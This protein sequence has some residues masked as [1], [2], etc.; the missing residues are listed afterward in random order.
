[1]AA[2]RPDLRRQS[3]RAALQVASL[4]VPDQVLEATPEH[5]PLEIL[6]QQSPVPSGDGSLSQD[7]TAS[8][9]APPRA[10][11]PSAVQPSAVAGV[12]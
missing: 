4:T 3:G 8:G 9:A 2:A 10:V 12:S 7:T 5:A 11:Q 6:V 1:M